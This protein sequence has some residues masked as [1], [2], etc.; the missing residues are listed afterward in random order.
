MMKDKPKNMKAMAEAVANIVVARTK[1]ITNDDIHSNKKTNELVHLGK[2][3]ASRMRDSAE[4]L[5]TLKNNFNYVRK[6]I[7]ATGIYHH[8]LKNKIKK[9]DKQI[10]STVTISDI[11][12]KSISVDDFAKKI[13]Q[14]RNEYLTKSDEKYQSGSFEDAKKFSDIADE[15]GKLRIYPEP[16]YQFSLTSSELEIVNNRS[17]ETKI[18]KMEDKVSIGVNA[19]IELAKRLIRDDYY[20]RRGLGLAMI[21]GR[22]MSE[23]FVSAKFQPLDED[24]YL[25]SGAI[26]KDLERGSFAD[27][28]EHEI[29]CLI[30]VDEFMYYFNLFREDEK[31]I[32]LA[33]KCK[34]SGSFTPV[35]RSIGFLTRYNAQKSLQALNGDRDAESWKFSDSRAM[36]VA[37]AWYLESKKP[38]GQRI[39]DEVIF[40][41]K[42][43]A[44]K[45]VET[46]LHYREFFVVPDSELQGKTLLDKLHDADEDVLRYATRSNLTTDRILKVHDYLCDYVSKNP[47]A[48]INKALLKRQKKKG[49]IGAAHDVAVEYFEMIKPYI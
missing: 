33:D 49:G 45:D 26:K 46:M 25:F 10:K 15:L 43:L 30:D 3:Q 1:K 34:E 8:L 11:L 18:N 4:S 28:E 21:S 2:E 6:Q 44:H 39:E 22:R 14:K 35:N 24:T 31:V 38:K 20:I 37:V 19:Y 5:N 9:L 42:Y 47:D 23:V 41:R 16:Y 17:E 27:E 36:S 48:K 40:Y 32:E 7:A 29:P 13:K 12:R